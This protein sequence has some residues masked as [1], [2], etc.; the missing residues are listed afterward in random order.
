MRVQYISS[1]CVLVEHAGV[2]VL[3]DP[4]LTDGIHYGSWYHYPPLTFKPEDFSDVDYIYVSH[5]HE[6]HM[7]LG[8]L[9]RLPRTIPILI[10]DYAEKYLLRI[11]QEE[12]FQKVTEVSHHSVF[13]L[14][15][16]FT[17]QILAADNCNPALCGRIFGCAMPRPYQRTSQIDSLAVFHGSGK[18]VVNT[19]DCPYA[20]AHPVC[21]DIREKYKTIDFLMVGYGGAGPYPQC[22][23]ELDE[24]EKLERAWRKRRQ[25]LKQTADYLDN[26]RPAYFLPFAGQYTLGGKLA[27]LNRFRGIPELD[28]LPAEL[29]PLMSPR[30]ISSQMVLLNSGEWF[31]VDQ[32]V[33]SRPYSP[34]DRIQRDRYVE[35]VL[36]QKKFIYEEEFQIPKSQWV[37]LTSK[38]ELAQKRMLHY[39][40]LYGYRSNW[41]IYLDAAQEH[42]YCV[43]FDGSPV[44][45]AARG[46]EREPFVRFG[47]D[48]SLL[49]MV[50]DRKAH[51]NNVDGG[52][53]LTHARRPDVFEP[54]LIHF[55][56]YLHC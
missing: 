25:F 32:G 8:T 29:G 27:R 36:A 7:D 47:L 34:I 15:G 48:Y 56:S 45:K 6:D 28:E 42:L 10:H 20:L 40:D 9:R 31:D 43:P 18:T 52:Q 2:K 35:E 50:L 12:G 53:H 13:P 22:F 1:A 23:V 16:D 19:N 3:C 55:I 11:L 5:V 39:Q 37:D 14:G 51:W 38:L 4:W 33:A 24:A 46:S 44:E 21:D 54:A 26:L 30:G 41:R 49:Q 17:V